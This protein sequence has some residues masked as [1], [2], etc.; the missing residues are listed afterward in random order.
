LPIDESAKENESA[1]AD[2]KRKRTHSQF[3]AKHHHRHHK[4]ARHGDNEPVH[5]ATLALAAT[6]MDDSF[7]IG[8]SDKDKTDDADIVDT[9]M[10]P[11]RQT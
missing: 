4:H 7:Y 1:D 8:D 2:R 9:E 10:V 11:I 3:H 6:G 5:L